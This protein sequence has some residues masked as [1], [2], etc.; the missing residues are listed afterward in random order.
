MF[1]FKGQSCQRITK[2][3]D[4]PHTSPDNQCNAG[5]NTCGIVMQLSSMGLPPDIRKR[6]LLIMT[7]H[8]SRQR[9]LLEIAYYPLKD[10]KRNEY[11]NKGLAIYYYAYFGASDDVISS[12]TPIPLSFAFV[13]C[14]DHNQVVF[15]C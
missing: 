14:I 7:S 9:Y 13:S 15:R 11:V 5:P 12:E 3:R 8:T 2:H 10:L 4:Y 1:R 6:I